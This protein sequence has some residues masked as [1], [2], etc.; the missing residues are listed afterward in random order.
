MK[1]PKKLSES[2]DYDTLKRSCKKV[3]HHHHRHCHH[4]PH[5]HRNDH[6][7]EHSRMQKFESWPSDPSSPIP[8]GASIVSY[9][10]TSTKKFPRRGIINI[11][12]TRHHHGHCNREISRISMLK[13]KWCEGHDLS[14]PSRKDIVD[15]EK[16][17]NV[18]TPPPNSNIVGS[19]PPCTTH[20]L[21][22]VPGPSHAPPTYNVDVAPFG[23]V[24]NLIH[25]IP[26]PS[27]MP[28]T[29]N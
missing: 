27:H 6:V 7:H 19:T 4:H 12:A 10:D 29:Y 1:S 14:P 25:D 18:S 13:C 22:D 17:N 28:P 5:H 3:P 9:D 2:M 15:V 24:G 11:G 26:S 8:R 23:R 20:P 16:H 21:N